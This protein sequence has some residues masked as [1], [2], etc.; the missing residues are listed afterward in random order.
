MVHKKYSYLN[1]DYTHGKQL[2]EIKKKT[3]SITKMS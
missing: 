2:P 3:E 1:T